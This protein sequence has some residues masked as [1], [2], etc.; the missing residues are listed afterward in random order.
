MSNKTPIQL[1]PTADEIHSLAELAWTVRNRAHLVGATAVGC[2][3][4]ANDGRAYSGC[5][6]EHPFRCHD[7]HAEVNAISSMVAAGTKGIVLLLIA[8]ERARFTPCGGCMDWIMLFATP[9]TRIGFQGK[10][11]GPITYHT[12]EELMPFYP[13]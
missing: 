4:F 1:T 2:A 6:I 7:I 5:N 10:E 9:E 3:I 11:G 8:A 13:I 12:P